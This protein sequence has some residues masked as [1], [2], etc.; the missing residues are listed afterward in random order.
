MT[1]ERRE[2]ALNDLA[3]QSNRRI[4]KVRENR[5]NSFRGGRG[6]MVEI[7]IIM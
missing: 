5:P 6:S 1:G 2:A 7:Y 4:V 3:A